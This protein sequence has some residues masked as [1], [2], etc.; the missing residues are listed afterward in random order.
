M[1]PTL[2]V[3]ST[4]PDRMVFPA[5][6]VLPVPAT[7]TPAGH[8]VCLG[9]EQRPGHGI[10]VEVPVFADLGPGIDG[11]DSMAPLLAAVCVVGVVGVV[12]DVGVDVDVPAPGAVVAAVVDVK[13][14]L[15]PRNLRP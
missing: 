13:S 3:G 6:P 9:S 5:V 1:L 14:P 11:T 8:A 4:E 12:G 15:L 10:Q 7:E 2:S